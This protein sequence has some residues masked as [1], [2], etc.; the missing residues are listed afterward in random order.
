MILEKGI[1]KLLTRE[2]SNFC[3]SGN[4]FN[5][6]KISLRK[7]SLEFPLAIGDYSV[8]TLTKSFTYSVPR[9][10]VGSQMHI[11]APMDPV[12]F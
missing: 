8:Q 4:T 7:S 11:T 10:A 1:W 12:E 2:A 5:A 9:S 6:A 3:P